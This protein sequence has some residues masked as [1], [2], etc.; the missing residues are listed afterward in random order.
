[1]LL[2]RQAVLQDILP[3]DDKRIRQSKVFAARGIDFFDAAEQVGLE[4]IMAKKADSTYTADRRSKEWLK[5]K[6]QRRQEVV[7]AGFTRNEG[8]SKVFSALILGVYEGE[9]LRYAG[10]VGTGFS[11]KQQK[12]M[13]ERFKPLIVKTNPFETDPN[14]NKPTRFRTQ[15][16]GAKPTWM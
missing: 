6:V 4:G 15:Q 13:M 3:T 2:E 8:T 7:I 11:D 5:I 9:Y 10:K 12:E 14:V 1:P 16:L